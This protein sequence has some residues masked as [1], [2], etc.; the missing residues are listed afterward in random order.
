M[1]IGIKYIKYKPQKI[2]KRNISVSN[3]S[4]NQ[5][6]GVNKFYMTSKLTKTNKVFD[7]EQ[8]HKDRKCP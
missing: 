1:Y 2:N 3:C 5:I 8:G 4:L 6:R 7:T